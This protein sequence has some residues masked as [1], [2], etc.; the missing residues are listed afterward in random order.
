[1]R[2]DESE[3]AGEDSAPEKDR[4]LMVGKLDWQGAR[5]TGLLYMTRKPMR[6][7]RRPPDKASGQH[8]ILTELQRAYRLSLR[9]GI[10][11]ISLTAVL[12]ILTMSAMSTLPLAV[13][14]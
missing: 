6:P 5:W 2:D 8:E 9:I 14:V 12:V 3:R 1:M 10:A 7:D 11:V 13:N 4:V